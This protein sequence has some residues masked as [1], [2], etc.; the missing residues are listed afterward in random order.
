MLNIQIGSFIFSHQN[1]AYLNR[2]LP[3]TSDMWEYKTVDMNRVKRQLK[4]DLLRIQDSQCAYC[5]QD[6]DSR[7]RNEEDLPID[8]DREHIAAKT[9]Y[10]EFMFTESN[11]VLTC[12]TCNRTLKNDL[13]V[14]LTYNNNYNNCEFSIVHPIL[15]NYED[16]MIFDEEL[17]ICEGYITQ[18]GLFTINLF[19][20]DKV[21]LTK[22]RAEKASLIADLEGRNLS[23]EII[24]QLKRILQYTG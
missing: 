10:Q 4:E 2:L 11:L 20:L 16:H 6:L 21:Y 12:I 13:D 19:E 24:N 17:I 9:D 18:K 22:K 7:R 1:R 5:L 8:G 14:I 23:P 3:H 15:N